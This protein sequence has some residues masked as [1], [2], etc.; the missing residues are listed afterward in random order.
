MVTTSSETPTSS[1]AQSP[2]S[3]EPARPAIDGRQRR[4]LA[5][6]AVLIG[7]TPLI[8]VPFVDDAVEAALTRRFVRDLASAR[9]VSLNEGDVRA[10]AFGDGGGVVKKI[11]RGVF[12]Y[13][14]KKLFRKTFFFLEGKRVVDLASLTF[15]RGYLLDVAF[16]RGWAGAGA[17]G[18]PVLEAIEKACRE[19]GTS[20][21]EHAVRTAFNGSRAAFS[22]AV[23]GVT[24]AI[25]RARGGAEEAASEAAREADA[26]AAPVGRKLEESLRAVPAE[27]FK[28]LTQAFAMALGKSL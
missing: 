11:A 4:T 3:P 5:T 24:R 21:V 19:A 10:L 12:V 9:G 13:P 20:P 22:G 25:K 18:G 1:P 7:L 14:I 2:A 27:Y 16:A 8:P 15:C 17:P 6:Y 28:R 23:E 26:A